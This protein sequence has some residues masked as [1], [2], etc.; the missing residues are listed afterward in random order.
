MRA[1]IY[2]SKKSAMSEHAKK[3]RAL[4]PLN[5][6]VKTTLECGHKTNERRKAIILISNETVIQRLVYCRICDKHINDKN[7]NYDKSNS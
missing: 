5:W 2:F 7:M 6:Y 3:F 1:T 4:H